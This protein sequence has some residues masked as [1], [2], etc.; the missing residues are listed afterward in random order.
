MTMDNQIEAALKKFELLPDTKQLKLILSMHE[1]ASGDVKHQWVN[2]TMITSTEPFRSAVSEFILKSAPP[3]M[4]AVVAEAMIRTQARV[5]EQVSRNQLLEIMLADLVE[6]ESAPAYAANNPFN[7]TI[8]LQSAGVTKV[9]PLNRHKRKS[10]CDLG[11][12]GDSGGDDFNYSDHTEN[13]VNEKFKQPN[14]HGTVPLYTTADA[15]RELKLDDTGVVLRLGTKDLDAGFSMV[16][17][18]TSILIY[19]KKKYDRKNM[20]VSTDPYTIT[21]ETMTTHLK[22]YNVE[23][24]LINTPYEDIITGTEHSGLPILLSYD[25]Y[26]Y[27][28]VEDSFPETWKH[29]CLYFQD[30]K[31]LL[32]FNPQNINYKIGSVV[33]KKKMEGTFDDYADDVFHRKIFPIV[34]EGNFTYGLKRKMIFRTAYTIHKN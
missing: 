3:N 7:S 18:L 33:I 2:T 23:H 12:D 10:R 26:K 13:G 15:E 20:G 8:D 24:K 32:T 34:R 11:E 28:D 17:A 21:L 19:T 27:R 29:F 9:T 16:Y 22:D 25:V 14:K 5:D 1:N 6:I 31:V 30:N 4:Y